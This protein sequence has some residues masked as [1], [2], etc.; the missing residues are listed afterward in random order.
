VDTAAFMEVTVVPRFSNRSW[1]MHTTGV[2]KEVRNPTSC[3]PPQ[4]RR[5]VEYDRRI[6]RYASPVVA[7]AAVSQYWTDAKQEVVDRLE[8]ADLFSNRFDV[9]LLFEPVRHY[10]LRHGVAFDSDEG[11]GT[12]RL[13]EL[14]L[15]VLNEQYGAASLCPNST[16]LQCCNRRARATP[17]S[18]L[19]RKS[20]ISCACF[21]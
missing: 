9:A 5:A 18:T 2:R 21:K 13:P 10:R 6:V 16:Y 15:R 19:W 12:F 3:C 7:D 11:A 14:A 1:A 8:A 20:A 4:H 17:P